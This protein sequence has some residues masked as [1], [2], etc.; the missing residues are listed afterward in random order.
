MDSE[1]INRYV[2]AVGREFNEPQRSDIEKEVR[3]LIADMLDA[4]T[5]GQAATQKDVDLVLTEL[6]NPRMLADKYRDHK[7]YLIGPEIYPSY[8][9]IIQLVW[10]ALSISMVVLFVIQTL[11]T[12]SEI[13]KVLVSTLTTYLAGCVQAFAWVTVFFAVAERIKPD[14][15][16]ID[17]DHEHDWKLTD[18]PE[19]PETK[20]L[21][22]RYEPVVGITFALIF[23][24]L[25]TFGI[26]L[27]GIWFFPK[28]GDLTIVPFFTESVFRSYLPLIWGLVL[29][30]VALEISKFHLECW[31]IK[32]TLLDLLNQIVHLMAGLVMFSNPHIWNQNFIQ[33]LTQVN[34][35][36]T[37]PMAIPSME[38]VWML[39]TGNFVL[40]IG[41]IYGLTILLRGLKIY[42]MWRQTR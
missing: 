41:L 9:R 15:V 42:R 28:S 25:F 35:F 31:T 18:L 2:Y 26:Q 14:Q 11:A 8:L 40:M 1:W 23:G 3:G 37:S 19:V 6:G 20:Y 39:V 27:F 7:R 17:L 16:K 22:P 32:L 13:L 12:P 33:Q 36:P 10:G 34:M 30:D 29:F 4:R 24:I 38:R 5:N 21:I